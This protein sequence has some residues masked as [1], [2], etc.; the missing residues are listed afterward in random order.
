MTFTKLKRNVAV[1]MVACGVWA[2]SESATSPIKTLQKIDVVAGTGAE[3]VA[4]KTVTVHY[5]GW[6]YDENTA[7]NHGRKIDSSHDRGAPFPFVLGTGAVI[8]GWDQGVAGMKVGGK[9]TLIIPPELAYGRSGFGSVPGN[10]AL[11]F[12]IE[13]LNVQ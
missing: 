4:G 6:L 11:I 8:E 1:A 5:T 13:L 9:R 2:C 12:D 3:A 10:A 7:D